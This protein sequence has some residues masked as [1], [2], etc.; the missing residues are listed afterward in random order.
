MS[1][2]VIEG[3]TMPHTVDVTL[4]VTYPEGFMLGGTTLIGHPE[5]WAWQA[6][7]GDPLIEEGCDVKVELIST[8]EN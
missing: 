6:I 2:F 7:I 3:D 1:D 5:D 8:T 4:R